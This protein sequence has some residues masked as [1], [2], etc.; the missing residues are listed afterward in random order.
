[1]PP[2]I[3]GKLILPEK[4]LELSSDSPQWGDDA[5]LLCYSKS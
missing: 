4:I 1:M 3:S 2:F 5:M